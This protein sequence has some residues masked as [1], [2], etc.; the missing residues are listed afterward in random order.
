MSDRP[1]PRGS[2]RGPHPQVPAL[3]EQAVGHL[4]QGNAAAAEALLMQALDLDAADPDA[5]QVMGLIREASGRSEEAEA[6]Y[7]RSLRSNI[8]QAHVHHNLGSLLMARGDFDKAIT[9]FRKA[10]RSKSDYAAA[11]VGLASIQHM[12]G[13]LD[14]AEESFRRAYLLQPGS[15]GAANGLA[16]VLNDLGRS[17]E[18][19]AIL[20]QA[21]SLGHEAPLQQ[22]MMHSTLA[23]A[24]ESQQ[25]LQDA[26]ACF[27]R[28]IALAPDQ[29]PF[30]QNRARILQKLGR[31]EAAISEYERALSIEPG[32]TQAHR[33]LNELLYRLDRKDAFLGSYDRALQGGNGQPS[34]V[35]GKVRFLLEGERFEEAYAC[36]NQDLGDYESPVAHDLAGRASMGLGRFDEALEAYEAGTRLAPRNA[37][38]LANYATA[39]LRA[40]DAARALR[41]ARKALRND[42]ANQYALSIEGLAM[43]LLGQAQE[44]TLNDYDSFVQV[45]DLEPP[46]GYT[47]IHSFNEELDA[48][49]NRL[50]L[51]R[52]ENIDQTLRH[53]TQTLG[54]IFG[55]G[56]GPVELLVARIEDAVGAYI[57]AMKQDRKHPFLKRR[58]SAFDFAGSW[59]SRLHDRG[60]HSNH[61]HVDGWI[62][63]CYYIAL[64]DVVS[65][66]EEKQGWLK[67]GEPEFDIGIKE[68][69][70]RFVQPKAGRLVLF[71]SYFWHGTVPFRSSQARTTIAFDVVP[72]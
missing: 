41:L 71:P 32:D 29:A 25:R 56:H 37:L 68:P 57:A 40:G 24:L 34:L 23:L 59:S 44:E 12:L 60:F 20:R 38:L 67:F 36:L 9:S 15:S 1:P 35:L 11:Y 43:R 33:E 22:A 63:S 54:N 2:K 53:G 21:L 70:R 66:T 47:D 14:E 55:A 61:V 72:R 51:D 31:Y 10:I 62:S 64:P 69:V 50:H 19:E 13:K 58:S 16:S 26:L 30:I 52:K 6:F 4:R 48:Y 46:E 65:D 28:A 45:F 5:L 39:A 18:A 42:S 17:R 27:D 7:R 49:L 3:C 8:R